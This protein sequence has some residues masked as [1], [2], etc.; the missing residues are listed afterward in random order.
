MKITPLL[1]YP[2]LQLHIS[3]RLPLLNGCALP[4][5]YERSKRSSYNRQMSYVL[6]YYLQLN[7]FKLIK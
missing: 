5:V 7:I 3:Y 6:F 4:P 1:H 2:T